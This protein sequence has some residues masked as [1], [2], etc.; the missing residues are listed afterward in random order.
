MECLVWDQWSEWSGCDA[1]C[2]GGSRSRSRICQ[3]G[4]AGDIGCHV[5]G[6]SDTDVCNEHDCPGSSD[7]NVKFQ[8]KLR[9]RAHKL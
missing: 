2:G 8:I 7:C 4:N 3:N 1:T 9:L 6:T 5:G